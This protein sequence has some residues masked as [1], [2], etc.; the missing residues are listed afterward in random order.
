MVAMLS[1][2]NEGGIS[3]GI[4]KVRNGEKRV[5]LLDTAIWYCYV[6]TEMYEAPGLAKGTLHYS[7]I[8]YKNGESEEWKECN[9]VRMKDHGE[10]MEPIEGYT[11]K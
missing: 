4:E 6:Q 2:S 9:R 1:C 7:S 11:P 8:R 10:A 5:T 3:D